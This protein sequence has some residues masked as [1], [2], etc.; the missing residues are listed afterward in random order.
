MTYLSNHTITYTSVTKHLLKEKLN[1][2]L[3]AGDSHIPTKFCL[4]KK[5]FSVPA[6]VPWTSQSWREKSKR[7][8]LNLWWEWD[9]KS[10]S[11]HLKTNGGGSLMEHCG[12]ISCKK[13]KG[14]ILA[15]LKGMNQN[16][17]LIWVRIINE[18]SKCH[19]LL[20][21]FYIQVASLLQ[22]SK[23][24]FKNVHFGHN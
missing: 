17:N 20:S 3:M 21:R 10:G 24:T 23:D 2:F 18:Q 16:L 8:P 7:R 4:I 22:K 15:M 6:F 11:I 14:H 12:A 9:V 19:I 5:A 1:E 13:K